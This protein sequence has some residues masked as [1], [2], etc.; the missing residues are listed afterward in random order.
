MQ[1]YE[2]YSCLFLDGKYKSNDKTCV[3]NNWTLDIFG[4]CPV[5]LLR[6]LAFDLHGISRLLRYA[7]PFVCKTNVKM[8]FL[9]PQN[10]EKKPPKQNYSQNE[11]NVLLVNA[12][13]VGILFV[14]QTRFSWWFHLTTSF[15]DTLNADIVGVGVDHSYLF[16]SGDVGKLRHFRLLCDD[17]EFPMFSCFYLF[18][19]CSVVVARKNRNK[20]GEKKLEKIL[21]RFSNCHWNFNSSN[22]TKF[23]RS[24]HFDVYSLLRFECGGRT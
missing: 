17:D 2:C 3:R 1:L 19:F 16:T 15:S 20:S 11:L 4:P 22:C 8:H 10:E 21:V 5:R 12:A 18:C 9:H 23:S 7:T 14:D 13:V 24:S 6:L